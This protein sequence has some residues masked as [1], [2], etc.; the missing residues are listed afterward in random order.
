VFLNG[1]AILDHSSTGERI[2]DDSFLLLF[3]A[4]HEPIRFK[5]P[6]RRFGLRWLRELDTNDPQAEPLELAP[7]AEL[8]LESRS[9]VLLRRDF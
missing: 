2:E 5:L 6:A 8:D 9:I 3:N 1:E 7:R 4:F